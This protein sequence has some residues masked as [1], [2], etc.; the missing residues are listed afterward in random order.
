MDRYG[1][2]PAKS[3]PDQLLDKPWT[4]YS[5]DTN[6]RVR[7]CWD[8]DAAEAEANRLERLYSR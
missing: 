1:I 5:R 4:V 2:R 7:T 3:N 8:R 6:R